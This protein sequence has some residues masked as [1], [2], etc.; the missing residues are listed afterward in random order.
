M[1]LTEREC[2][3]YRYQSYKCEVPLTLVS[4]MQPASSPVRASSTDP[5]EQHYILEITVEV[6]I[7]AKHFMSQYQRQRN[8]SWQIVV[9]TLVLL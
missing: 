9:Y 3:E 8:V 6:V 4:A 1:L 5:I 7:A 2:A